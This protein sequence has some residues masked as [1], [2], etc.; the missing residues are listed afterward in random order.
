M[1]A[2]ISYRSPHRLRSRPKF[3]YD[4]KFQAKI[5]SDQTF[6]TEIKTDQTFKTQVTSDQ[7]FQSDQ[8]NAF[9]LP[10]G[11]ANISQ[12]KTKK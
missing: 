5:I 3:L 4:Q 8:N 10:L 2:H 12:K 9:L 11:R 7:T 6:Q 1:R